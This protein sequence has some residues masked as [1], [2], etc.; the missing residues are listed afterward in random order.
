MNPTLAQP[1]RTG[2][3]R[4]R[5]QSALAPCRGAHNAVSQAHSWPCRKPSSCVV[6]TP[7]RRVVALHGRVIA[8]CR[9]IANSQVLAPLSRY[10]R[11]YRDTTPAKPDLLSCHNTISCIAT[12]SLACLASTSV[13]IQSLYRDTVSQPL[14]PSPVTI[15]RSVL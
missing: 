8:L 13:T 9:D 14:K 5:A 10:K 7:L 3:P 4:P 15:P 6:G 1:G 12:Q 11:L 2:A